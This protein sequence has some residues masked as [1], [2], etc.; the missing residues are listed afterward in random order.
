MVAG[1]E[2]TNEDDKSS[3]EDAL[4]GGGHGPIFLTQ[5]DEEM[6]DE[7]GIRIKE[8]GTFQLDIA[9]DG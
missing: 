2:N 1:S 8:G 7:S 9:L 4:I 5:E 3:E 6:E